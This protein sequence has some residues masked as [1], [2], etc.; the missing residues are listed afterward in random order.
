[1]SIVSAAK[2][3]VWYHKCNKRRGIGC[4]N[5]KLLSQGGCTIWWVTTVAR[6]RRREQHCVTW[7]LTLVYA[8]LCH[9]PRHAM[10]VCVFV[11]GTTSRSCLR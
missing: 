10:C 1:M 11:S 7:S 6:V 3:K 4:T 8:W 9:P 5:T 2:E